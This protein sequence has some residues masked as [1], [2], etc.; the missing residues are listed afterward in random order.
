LIETLT[1][2][3]HKMDSFLEGPHSDE[4]A[5]LKEDVDFD[6]FD[7]EEFD[8]CMKKGVEDRG[9]FEDDIPF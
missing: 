7:P 5:N 3:G 6:M 8:T 9:D 2:K 4:L 1:L